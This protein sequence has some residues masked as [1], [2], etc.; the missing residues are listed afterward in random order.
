LYATWIATY[1]SPEFDA[2]VDSVIAVTDQLG[3]DLGPSE[4]QR[5]HD[6]FET[7][8][9]YEWMFWDAAYHQLQWPV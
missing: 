5:C 6:H 2:V 8:T 7:T 3:E 9:R 4:R 1:G